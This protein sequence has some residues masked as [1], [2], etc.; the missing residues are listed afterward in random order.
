M[1]WVSEKQRRYMNAAAARGEVSQSVV[2]EG[3]EASKGKKLPESADAKKA[4]SLKKW[5]AT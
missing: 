1:P 2:D 5:A 3:N 4:A